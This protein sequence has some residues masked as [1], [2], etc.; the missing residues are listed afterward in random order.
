MRDTITAVILTK[1]EAEKI[2]RCLESIRWADEIIV[3]DGESSDGTPEICQSYGA[4]VISH[5]FEGD[6]G[7]ERNIGND[8]ATKD[9]ILQ[10]DA[11]DVVT[12]QFQ[13]SAEEILQ[14]GS[15]HAAYRFRRTNCFL[16]R[17][18]RY[19]GWNHYSLHFFRRGKARYQGRVHHALIVDGSI[20]TLQAPVE[21]YPFDSL[22]PFIGR[23]NRYTSIEALELMDLHGP[24]SEKNLRYQTMVKPLKLF[25]K[26]YIKKQGFREGVQ[27]FIFA[28]LY[29]Y[30][31]FIKWIKYWEICD[32]V[33][34]DRLS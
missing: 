5:R 15:L 20:G 8:N 30:V 14:N 27:G 25:W 7:Q 21:H 24:A 17:W 26:I 18:M 12:A 19:G 13:K 3:V 32:K 6:F 1:N 23:Q 2:R 34:A 28:G 31:H 4:K 29:S 9:W 11:D 22:Q 10:L 16:G 33:K